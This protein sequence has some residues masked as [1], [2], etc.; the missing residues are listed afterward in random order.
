VIDCVVDFRRTTDVFIQKLK[1]TPLNVGA[2]MAENRS[3]AEQFKRSTLHPDRDDGAVF[4]TS[5]RGVVNKS[6]SCVGKRK[7]SF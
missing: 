5:G 6:C 7:S 4:A 1:K 3:R 2:D